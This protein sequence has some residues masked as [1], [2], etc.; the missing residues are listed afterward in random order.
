MQIMPNYK[1]RK[2]I[3]LTAIFVPNLLFSQS[4]TQAKKDTNTYHDVIIY[5]GESRMGCDTNGRKEDTLFMTIYNYDPLFTDNF[6]YA[7]MG[8]IGRPNRPLFLSTPELKFTYRIFPIVAYEYNVNNL[9][10]YDVKSPYT[11]LF[12][13]TGTGKENYLSGVHAQKVNNLSFG[14]DFRLISASGSYLREESNNT[15]GSIYVGYDHPNKKYGAFATYTFNILKP[16]ENGGIQTDSVFEQ[17]L[18]PLR[19]GVTI[20]LDQALNKLKTNALTLSQYYNPAFGRRD[21][22]TLKLGTIEQIFSFERKSHV[23]TETSP[24]T[25]NYTF[26]IRDTLNTYDSTSYTKAIN[27]FYWSNYSLHL[28]PANPTYL[29]IRAGIRHEYV[30]IADYTKTYFSSQFIPEAQAIYTYQKN[31]QIGIK[32]SYV[33]DG[34]TNN[35]FQASFW[36]SSKPWKGKSHRFKISETITSK[37]PDFFY[38]HFH[39]N[40]Y[41]WDNNNLAKIFQTQTNVEY[42]NK[43]A[44]VGI[45]SYTINNQIFID[46]RYQPLQFDQTLFYTQSYANVKFKYRSFNWLI[47]ATFTEGNND[48]ILAFPKFTTR[49]SL[50]FR[51]PMFQK[52]MQFETGVDL[53]YLSKYFAPNYV[54]AI[55]DYI[56][57]NNKQYGDFIYVNFFAGLKV[58]QFNA[59]FKIQNVAQ[60]LLGYNYMMMPHYPLPDRLFK[61]IILWRFY[62]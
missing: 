30:E 26:F 41:Q 15:G 33:I 4:E 34:Y 27:G 11:R 52:R 8:N 58:K 60:G 32:G 62:D 39:G 43:F 2:L 56:I 21:S 38:S 17:N 5:K 40:N 47:N 31:H 25:A 57:Q 24:D 12:Y 35:A 16:Q 53:M 46:E 55:G 9:N 44:E 50:L 59:M 49:Q 7:S 14:A 28:Q 54:P 22:A 42:S 13:T 51:F 36:A 10:I 23:F 29:F 6:L 45:S 20:K 1:L 37:M 48:T 18:E 61:L 3:L 19:D